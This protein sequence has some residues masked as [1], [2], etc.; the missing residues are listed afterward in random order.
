[1]YSI[2]VYLYESENFIEISLSEKKLYCV[3]KMENRRNLFDIMFDT[4]TENGANSDCDISLD[5]E[6]E[7]ESIW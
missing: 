6:S 4:D 7:I 3:K 2:Q 5:S 1:M